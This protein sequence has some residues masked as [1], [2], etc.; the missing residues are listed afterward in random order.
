[1]KCLI[2]A[3]FVAWIFQGQLLNEETMMTLSIKEVKEKYKGH[4]LAMPGVVSVGIG[5]DSD[6]K[7]LIVVGLDGLKPETLKQLPKALDGYPVR[8]EIIGPVKAQ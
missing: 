1:M 4:L 3:L 8:G 5:Q 6:G 2:A 7:P